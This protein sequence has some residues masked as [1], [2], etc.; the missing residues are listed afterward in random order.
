MSQRGSLTTVNG[1][2]TEGVEESAHVFCENPSV[3]ILE[4][5]AVNKPQKPGN[6]KCLARDCHFLF[7]MNCTSSL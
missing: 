6:K 5:A 3:A 2:C 7:D 1:L 4:P